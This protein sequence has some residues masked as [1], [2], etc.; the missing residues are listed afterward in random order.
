[1]KTTIRRFIQMIT[2]IGLIIIMSA[3]SGSEDNQATSIESDAISDS[4]EQVIN[5]S[6]KSQ[7][8]TM[9]SAMATDEASFRFLGMTMEGLY[10]LG[11]NAE[12]EE[13]IAIDH[14]Q[15][16]DGLEWTFNL[17]EDAVWSNG[18][19]V[20]AHDFVYAWQRVVD[21]ETGS[22]FGPYMMNDV[23]KNAE[24][25][26][27][28]D[29]DVDELGVAAID[30]YTLHVELDRPVPYFESLMAFGTFLPLNE[31]F[32]EEQ[33]DEYAQTYENLLFNGPFK[34]DDWE[35]TS[36]SWN[37]I[38]N[39]DFWDADTVEL[40]KITYEV[41]R[42]TNTAVDLFES[43][44]IDRV[45]L[46]SDLV[47]HYVTSDEYATRS[48]PVIY[49]LRMNQT[50]NEA[51]ANVNIRRAISRAFDKQA[52]TD[53]LLNNGS[54]PLNGFIPENFAPLPDSDKGIRE[55]NGDL[56][57]YNVDEAQEYW[58]KGLEELDKDSVEI[59]F[60]GSD[61]DTSKTINEYLAN[62]LE[63]NLEGLDI[64]LKEVP[65]EQALDLTNSMDYDIQ[66]S[67]AGTS[68]LD[69]S[70]FMDM[71]IT[72]SATNQMGYSNEEYDKLYEE[73]QSELAEPG[74]EVKRYENF[75]EA[76]KIAFDDAVIA[77]VY[78]EFV[79]MLV[80]P[81]IEGVITNPIGPTYEYKW[82]R[83]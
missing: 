6:N 45:E 5:L 23:I 64:T 77:P 57:E 37:V 34:L 8:P 76:E 26:N 19:P 83:V 31:D 81:K 36:D 20:T 33:G 60:L 14:E 79:A 15:S 25:I 65:S 13:G 46:S 3:C 38:K 7:I 35:S 67:A 42:D 75:A 30:D 4:N 68:N 2:V 52:L 48:K 27:N 58:E 40:E 61:S 17:R 1:M 51:L 32:V 12:I 47:D 50:R 63:S 44:K 24:E 41:V 72:D 18:D 62:Q 16:E 49:Y 22:E 39:E 9:D 10:R 43:G 21:P 78:Q 70:S 71:L 56:V 80:D 55:M 66:L 82:A 54:I 73:A 29:K 74:N 28:G 53:E 59:E 69:P 11:E